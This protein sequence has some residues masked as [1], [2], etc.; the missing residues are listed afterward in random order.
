VSPPVG[1]L[2]CRV[3]D[4]ADVTVLRLAGDLDYQTSNQLR[5]E[6]FE[7]ITPRMQDVRV[8]LAGLRSIDD[9]GIVSFVLVTRTAQRAA[10]HVKLTLVRVPQPVRASIDDSGLGELLAV[11]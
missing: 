6:V 4:L 9:V 1:K 10:P 5:D 11:E 3:E 2:A 8:D 7:L